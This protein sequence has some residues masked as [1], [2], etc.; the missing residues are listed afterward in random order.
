MAE[1]VRGVHCLHWHC[2]SENASGAD[3]KSVEWTGAISVDGFVILMADFT[4]LTKEASVRLKMAQYTVVSTASSL[5]YHRQGSLSTGWPGLMN[6][7]SQTPSAY[8][9]S[10]LRL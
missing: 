8:L 6:R 7:Q 5:G 4:P 1:R 9:Y 3:K 2:L 10:A